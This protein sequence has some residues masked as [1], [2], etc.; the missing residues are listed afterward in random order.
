[1]NCWQIFTEV[2]L[3]RLQATFICFLIQLEP[4]RY[5]TN[6][7]D[8]DSAFIRSSAS[9]LFFQHVCCSGRSRGRSS[10]HVDLEASWSIWNSNQQHHDSLQQQRRGKTDILHARISR[11]FKL[12][13]LSFSPNLF[14]YKSYTRIS[15]RLL[16]HINLASFTS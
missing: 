4:S 8:L 7:C 10:G 16:Q 2:Y 12:I 9:Y 1:M 14:S 11:N 3:R 6:S 15:R 13:N 5:H